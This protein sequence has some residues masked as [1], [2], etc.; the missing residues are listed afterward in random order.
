[1]PEALAV[2]DAAL[3]EFSTRNAVPAATIINPISEIDPVCAEAL[4]ALVSQ[5][6]EDP[7]VLHMRDALDPLLDLRNALKPAEPVEPVEPV[8]QV[9]EA[10]SS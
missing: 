8:E 7:G 6:N 2:V 4:R 5:I 10:A 3:R 1:M 9:E